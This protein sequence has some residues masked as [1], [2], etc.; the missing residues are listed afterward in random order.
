[1]RKIWV[2]NDVKKGSKFV[3]KGYSLSDMLIR[4]KT[5]ITYNDWKY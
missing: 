2:V 5:E 4:L 1:M 3:L